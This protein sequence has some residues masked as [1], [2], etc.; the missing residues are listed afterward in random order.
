MLR[1]FPIIFLLI[2]LIQY[3]VEAADFSEGAGDLYIIFYITQNGLTGHVGI[4]VDN[5][6]IRIRDVKHNG[7][8]AVAYDTIKAGHLTYID[9]WGPPEISFRELN[10]DLSPRYYKLPRSSAEERITLNYFLN[11]GLPHAYNY[12]CDAVLKV[13]TSPYEDYLLL[14][15]ADSVISKN[16]YFNPKKYNCTDFVEQLLEAHFGK[17]IRAKEFL[18]LAWSTTPNKFYRRL[19]RHFDVKVIKG[20]GKKVN[21]PFFIERFIKTIFSKKKS[22]DHEKLP[23]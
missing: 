5:Y 8:P 15:R 14:K 3:D 20:P 17:R 22:T 12:P 21:R 7:R 19:T 13:P 10:K 23:D 18:L 6:N 9:L 4:A 11:R 2:A 16:D 1:T